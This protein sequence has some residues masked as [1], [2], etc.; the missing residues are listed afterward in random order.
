MLQLTQLQS[1]FKAFESV[2]DHQFDR[3]ELTH[4][5]YLTT[6]E[7]LYFG[8]VDNLKQMTMLWHSCQ[9]I[10]SSLLN[11]QLENESLADDAKQAIEERLHL[12][13]QSVEQ[14]N[15]I[16]VINE[17]AMTKLDQLTLQL[18]SIQTRDG[19]S[20]IGLDTAMNEIMHL[21]NRTEQYDINHK[22]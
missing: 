5:R 8:A 4:K 7:Q 12:H 15:A 3:D 21:I 6:A 22:Q 9:A 18:S 10:D 20:E 2:L 16:L 1:K 19:L 14:I 13:Q 11:K 17:Q